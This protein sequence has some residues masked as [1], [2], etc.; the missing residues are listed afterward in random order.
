MSEDDIA[1]LRPLVR[2]QYLPSATLLGAVDARGKWLAFMGTSGDELEALFVHPDCHRR[3][4]GR[5]L[6]EHAMHELG[7][8]RVD[9][10]EQNPGAVAFYERL[11]FTVNGHSPTDAQGHPFPILHMRLRER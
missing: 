4:L 7:A 8:T 6:A 3:G 10:N 5:A 1:A 11:G 2:E 9:V